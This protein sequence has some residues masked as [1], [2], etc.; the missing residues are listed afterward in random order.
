M[1]AFQ[2]LP[3][4][5]I[6]LRL[7]EQA[8][9]EAGIRFDQLQ[10]RLYDEVEA[11]PDA[12]EAYIKQLIDYGLLEYD[13][14]VSGIDPDW[15]QHLTPL[16]HT[17]V[18]A[19]VPHLSSLVDTLQ[20][21]RALSQRFG[22]AEAPAR[23]AILSEAY[24]AF[25]AVC[26]RIHKA[27][28]LPAD[29]R[30][31]MDVWIAKKQ[32]ERADETATAEGREDSS[33][34][35][36]TEDQ[37]FRH[38]SA[39]HFS[40]KPEQLFYEDT[41]RSLTPTVDQ[42]ALTDWVTTLHDF[43]S[44]V[45]F[46]QAYE[47]ERASMSHYFRDH[48]PEGDDVRLL[49]F[50]EDYYRDI[51]KPAAE[52]QKKEDTAK[53]NTTP[54]EPPEIL[55]AIQARRS[56]M[57]QWQKQLEE[58]LR[59]EAHEAHE[60]SLDIDVLRRINNELA[61]NTENTNPNSY[62]SFVQFYATADARGEDRLMG[63]L[64]GVFPGY[65]K[66]MS[67]FMHIFDSSV[68]DEVRDW[69]R[70]VMGD[71]ALFIED[72]DASYFNANLHPPL[73][74]FEVR[75]PGG[76]N[77]LPVHQQLPITDFVVRYLPD[78]SALALIHRPSG[79][80]AYPFDLGFQGHGGRSQL[81]QLLEKFT[82]AEYRSFRA[83]INVAN[84]VWHPAAGAPSSPETSLSSAKE[85]IILPR[86]TLGGKIVVQRKTWL[87]PYEHLPAR[88]A[89]ASDADYFLRVRAWQQTQGIPDHVFVYVNTY[90]NRPKEGD[91]ASEQRLRKLRRDD[92]KPQFIS[93]ANPL[94]V[95]LF[96]KLVKKI[97]HQ[98]KIEEMLPGGEQML[99]Q[100]QQR[101]VSEW[102]VQWYTATPLDPSV[103]STNYAYE[104]L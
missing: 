70:S 89:Q 58:H 49:T 24:D 7:L 77:S 21:L 44:E 102:V 38:Q 98:M 39:T 94:L 65:G 81:F 69:N 15:D 42:K 80:R 25:R 100:Q 55:P 99:R 73:L 68:L 45:S 96:E 97:P 88:E 63:V 32:Q 92:Y 11:T 10:V 93:L 54:D 34:K 76:H 85:V 29:E 56:L 57:K 19:R 2:R 74:P 26:M 47:D 37:P 3:P 20:H 33:P 72:C 90:D 8:Q 1:E 64:N 103:H 41:T 48:Y 50:Y 9:E 61:I 84:A 23:Q 14:G 95:Q 53:E 35:E 22:S 86:L 16:L 75:M 71:D 59:S 66:M 13:L 82:Y 43:L 18:R 30:L 51:K 5:P 83:V 6:V 12:L 17:L 62:G 78:S 91:E 104:S 101:Y 4:H 67:R 46:F 27:A 28:D 36:E 79:K 52:A 87:V 60:V 40:F 31:P